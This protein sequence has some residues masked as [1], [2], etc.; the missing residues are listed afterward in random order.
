MEFAELAPWRRLVGEDKKQ[1]SMLVLMS[2][3]TRVPQTHPLRAIKKLADEARNALASA[4]TGLEGRITRAA[5]G[6]EPHAVRMRAARFSKP[7]DD[8]R[9]PRLEWDTVRSSRT[10]CGRHPPVELLTNGGLSTTTPVGVMRAV[11]T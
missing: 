6:G 2:P 3:E 11:N 7:A 9:P 4:A 5:W 1:S 10:V 8:T